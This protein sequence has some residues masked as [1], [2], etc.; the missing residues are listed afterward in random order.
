[1]K[2]SLTTLLTILIIL[3]A[4]QPVK[5]QN[6]EKGD[7]QVKVGIG[8]PNFTQL[9][10]NIIPK[11][12]EQRNGLM[13]MPVAKVDYFIKDIVSL[14]IH[15][16][17]Q[18]SVT[19]LYEGSFVYENQLYEGRFGLNQSRYTLALAAEVH[20][21]LFDGKVDVYLGGLLGAR[22][23]SRKVV[24]ELDSGEENVEAINNY[25]EEDLGVNSSRLASSNFRQRLA[26][27]GGLGFPVAGPVGLYLE[28]GFG[29]PLVTVGLSA[30]L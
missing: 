28:A 13:I 2:R 10:F 27:Y 26:L 12:Q 1:M 9:A 6:F 30:T 22:I 8:G 24:A 11:G 29:V 4:V 18:R 17:Y 25:L 5:A 14:G 19:D 20:P 3:L 7:I 23:F 16:N 15:L 21:D